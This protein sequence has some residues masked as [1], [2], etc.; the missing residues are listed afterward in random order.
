MGTK[1]HK[2]KESGKQA[3]R[4]KSERESAKDKKK[5]TEV[6]GEMKEKRVNWK[7]KERKNKDHCYGRPHYVSGANRRV[8]RGTSESDTRSKTHN[9]PEEEGCGGARKWEEKTWK[10]QKQEDGEN[11]IPDT[12][13]TDASGETETADIAMTEESGEESE[14][15]KRA[16]ETDFPAE[17]APTNRN[18]ETNRHVLGG[19]WLMQ[20]RAYLQNPCTYFRSGK[21]GDGGRSLK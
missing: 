5:G 14:E 21:E 13:D 7:K 11:G 15:V 19:T 12:E 9:N 16:R 20:V 3:Q 17:V 4:H 8:P 1:R 18:A 6:K 2:V 10:T